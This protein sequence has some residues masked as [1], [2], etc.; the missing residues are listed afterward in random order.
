MRDFWTT[1]DLKARGK[2][3][4]EIRRALRDGALVGVRP[5]WFAR[6]GAD[7]VLVRAVRVGGAATAHSAA[8]VRG[9]WIPPDV[10]GAS[11]RRPAPVRTP[12]LRV[13]V[14]KTTTTARLRDPDDPS[15]A[16]GDRPDVGLHWSD[17]AM[18]RAARPGGIVPVLT[19]LR[20]VF[21][22]EPPER[23]LAV[24]DSALHHRFL[25]PADLPALS[26]LLPAHLAPVV[27]SAD[28]R[29]E[30]GI[31]TV[32]RCLLSAAGLRVEPQAEIPGIGRVDLLVEGRLI[33]E[34]D[35]RQWHDGDAFEEDR[36]RDLVAARARYRVLRFTWHQVLFR[37]A[38]VEAAVLAALVAA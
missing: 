22:V 12:V 32:V 21:R 11:F 13:A 7:P 31:E 2:T 30:S 3:D 29:A 20:D 37:W 9:L 19:M 18:V 4:R 16:L 1:A 5:G 24:V 38:E 17:P 28:G 15:R 35:G 36:R 23:A 6:P 27:A 34:V 25:R 33:V 8:R 10:Q 14:A 26:A